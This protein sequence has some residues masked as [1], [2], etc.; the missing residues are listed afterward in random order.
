MLKTP[1]RIVLIFDGLD[2]YN[3]ETSSDITDMVKNIAFSEPAEQIKK[4]TSKWLNLSLS[5]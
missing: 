1:E 3:T 4:N 5:D 2:E